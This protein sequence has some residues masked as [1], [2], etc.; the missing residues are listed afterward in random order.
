YS[1]MDNQPVNGL[2]FYRIKETDADG[3]F[4]YS[5]IVRLNLN[6]NLSLRAYPLP[7]KDQVTI[8]HAVTGKGTLSIT[9]TD[10]RLVK[11]M[12][13]K[14]DLDQSIINI[15][16]LKAGFYIVRFVNGSHIESIKLVKE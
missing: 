3:K 12:D 15:S 10:G 13:V 8:E 1:F 14:P 2:A 4:R 5:T 9:T 6:R 11:Q 7:A 16:N